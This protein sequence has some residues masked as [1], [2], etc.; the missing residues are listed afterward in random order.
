[1]RKKTSI[2]K[3]SWSWPTQNRKNDIDLLIGSDFYWLLFTGNVK[4][5]NPQ[6]PVGVETKFRWVLNG[7]LKGDDV[8]IFSNTDFVSEVSRQVLFINSDRKS[9]SLDLKSKLDRF[10]NLESIDILDNEKHSQEHFIKSI[11]LNE[12]YWYEAKLPFKENHALLT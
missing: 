9:E 7:P 3:K 12:K 8:N 10:W 4:F 5:G 11:Y 2:I 1:M 6:E